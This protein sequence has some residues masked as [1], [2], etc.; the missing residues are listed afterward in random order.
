MPDPGVNSLIRIEFQNCRLTTE[1][2]V[3]DIRHSSSNLPS[4]FGVNFI[5]LST[6]SREAIDRIVKNALI[7]KLV[8]HESD[9][10]IPSIGEKDI[11]FQ[12]DLS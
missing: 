11:T 2:E 7:R 6:E 8:N 9:V 10:Q 5:G 1:V 4:G 12:F 3:L